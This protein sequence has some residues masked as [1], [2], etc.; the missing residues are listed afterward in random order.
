MGLDLTFFDTP[1]AEAKG[2]RYLTFEVAASAYPE[3]TM[4]RI[5]QGAAAALTHAVDVETDQ[6]V[7]RKVQRK[8]LLN[9][10]SLVT[11]EEPTCPA[12]RKDLGLA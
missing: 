3:R 12:C 9:D 5:T 8:H 1:P 11:A 10:S 7:C 2:R 4:R 6:P